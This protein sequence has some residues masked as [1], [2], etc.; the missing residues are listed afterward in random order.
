[1]QTPFHTTPAGLPAIAIPQLRETIQGAVIA[2]DDDEY[3]AARALRFAGFDRHPGAVV[4]AADA[5]DVART[6]TFARDQGIPLAVR[7]GG[8]SGAGHGTVDRG[9]VLDL[10]PMKTLDID[11]ANRVAW[12]E[13]GLTAGEVTDQA[14]ALGLAVP[15][16]D[17]GSVGIGGIT[18]AGGLGFLVRQHGLTID[19]LLAAEIVTAD[20]ELHRVDAENEPD[21]FWAIRGGGG[22][23]GVATRFRYRLHP[24]ETV[25][26]GMLILPATPE[27]VTG[28]IEAAREAPEALSAIANV[29]PAPP[30]PFI[31]A[32][33]HGEPIIFAM[34]VH[35]S[36]GEAGERAMAPFRALASPI[37]DR[38]GA[39]RYP[40]I[41]M[42]DPDG[43][44]IAFTTRTGYVDDIDRDAVATTLDALGASTAMMKALQIRVLGGAMARVPA[45]ETAFAHRD[46]PIMVN[47]AAMFP[48]PAER[49]AHTAWA[50][51]VV[52]SL[53]PRPGAYVGFLGDEGPGRVREAY[54]AAT[55]ERLAAIKAKVDPDNLFR[56]TQNIPPAE[57]E[58]EEHTSAA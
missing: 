18:L 40:E 17:T 20:G 43:P 32:H 30:M 52:A 31:P 36:G 24:V 8:H 5:R 1:M 44:P 57:T 14:G 54:D 47:A 26:G 12:A 49:P 3:D 15:F 19:S 56:S 35:A 48:D 7:G 22:N 28:F 58:D 34:L 39:M 45:G 9:I 50:E 38:I 33:R 11:V 10:S 53:D 37:V 4:R 21:L 46:A 41:F 25:T 2:P 16:G 55:W 27:T 42:D 51:Q 13:A 6:V 29:M 23:F